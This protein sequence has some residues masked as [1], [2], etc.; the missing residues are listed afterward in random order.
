[1]ATQDTVTQLIAAVRRVR[2]LVPEAAALE[3]AGHD[4][5]DPS[6][7]RIAWDDADARDRLVS[8]LVTDALAVLDAVAGLELSG[9]AADAVGL[10][11]LVASQDVEPSE[12]EGSWRIARQT[13]PDRVISTVDPE[14]RHIHKTVNAYRNGYKAHVVVESQTG[15]ICGQT[16]TPANVP[17]GA[18]GVGLMVKEPEG[19][20]VLADSAYGSGE[21]RAALRRRSTASPPSPGP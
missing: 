10:L 12:D 9:E 20:Q 4:Y 2:R 21:T 5:S 8:A 18:T 15:L 16:L 11:A 13:A 7:P 17:D 3:L 14:S 1:V 19:R 6:K